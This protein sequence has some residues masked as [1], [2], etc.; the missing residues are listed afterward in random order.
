MPSPQLYDLIHDKEIYNELKSE[1]EV[2]IDDLKLKL[3]QTDSKISNL[4]RYI[5]MSV[6]VVSN[7]SKYW[8]LNNIEVKKRTQE[9]VFPEGLSLDIKN[10][11]Y[12]TKNVNLFFLISSALSMDTEGINDKK[13]PISRLLLSLPYGL[14]AGTRLER[15]TFGL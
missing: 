1:L 9:L 3:I 7:I 13:Q 5:D 8:G 10:R 12:L 15:A 14:V 4:D 6:D 11:R 2:K